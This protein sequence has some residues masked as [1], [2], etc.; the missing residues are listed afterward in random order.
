MDGGGA[1]WM[2]CSINSTCHHLWPW[3]F[4]FVVEDVRHIFLQQYVYFLIATVYRHLFYPFPCL[5]GGRTG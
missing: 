3:G 2:T 1:H 5:R 4:V